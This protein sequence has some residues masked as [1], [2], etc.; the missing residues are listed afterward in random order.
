M[1]EPLLQGSHPPPPS[2]TPAWQWVQQLLQQAWS[3]WSTAAALVAPSDPGQARS[4]T[5]RAATEDEGAAVPTATRTG[6]LDG[7]RVLT[8]LWI[9][10]SNVFMAMPNFLI[11]AGDDS[12]DFWKAMF[13]SFAMRG[14]LNGDLAIDVLLLLS[15]FLITQQL[16]SEFH[17]SVMDG[18]D[19]ASGAERA[20]VPSP[21]RI[22][23][24]FYGRR[25]LRL[26]PAYA[27]A[28]LAAYLT[29]ASVPAL[30]FAASECTE[31][32]WTY[33]VFIDNFYLS[34]C[35][36]WTW[37][38]ALGLQ[39]CVLSPPL[40]WVTVRYDRWAVPL[41]VALV[42]F[43]VALYIG[44]GFGASD[45]LAYF[46]AVETK[47]YTRMF[48]YVLGMLVAIRVEREVT[49]DAA[50]GPDEARARWS[51]PVRRRWML[52][53]RI[54]FSA[55]SLSLA[56]CTTYGDVFG[57]PQWYF[58]T[59]CVSPLFA[60]CMAYVVYDL[61]STRC[62]NNAYQR[63]A[64]AALS[65]RPLY[66]L[67]Q[68]SYGVFLVHM[69]VVL[70]FYRQVFRGPVSL[71]SFSP[72]PRW[73][74]PICV[75]LFAILSAACAVVLYFLVERPFIVVGKALC[76]SSANGLPVLVTTTLNRA[77]TPNDLD[78][79]I[80]DSGTSKQH[81]FLYMHT[82]PVVND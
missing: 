62:A 57:D 14:I 35:M 29:F 42:A 21:L 10:A 65:A 69:V 30:A 61:V 71:G 27:G 55:A 24:R 4:G 34:E 11:A 44:L 13:E 7:L 64:A 31:Y 49:T 18:V 75:F 58:R 32:W 37:P 20:A 39:L 40:L 36:V 41:L 53:L 50:S 73:F 74:Y 43:S 68:L 22:T 19:V 51:S 15:G 23:G 1:L 52:A 63:A 28:L 78:G 8:V 82:Q 81:T 79:G 12:Y 17:A 59:L 48:A 66:I 72:D 80:G 3:P 26:L 5:G 25:L 38:I 16:R 2:E 6:A 46:Y 70:P 77:E 47:P 76:R 54:L 60:V 45:N 33:L 67:A 56:L 9:F